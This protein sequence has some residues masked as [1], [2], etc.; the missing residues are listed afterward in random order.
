M[1]N[2]ATFKDC[3]KEAISKW[4]E[5]NAGL[6]MITIPL[7]DTDLKGEGEKAQFVICKPNKGV[8]SALG[9]YGQAKELDKINDLF[10][11]SCV[12]GGDMKYIKG[13]NPD[14]QMITTV[15]EEIADLMKKKRVIS[16]NL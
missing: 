2:L 12:L 3:T 14:T 8:M 10:L 1:E 9:E 4:K 13:D 7:D 5:T 6:K 16:K 15:I 11:N